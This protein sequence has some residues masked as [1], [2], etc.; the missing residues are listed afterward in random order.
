[1]PHTPVTGYRELTEEELADMN[2]LKEMEA[3][4]L[5]ELDNLGVKSI[6]SLMPGS[7]ELPDGGKVLQS[8]CYTPRWLNI[9][10]TQIQLGFMAANRAIARP[11]NER[12]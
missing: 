3:N 8:G 5:A 1:M 2:L 7:D 9:A 12:N 6:M 10:R 4:I 11:N